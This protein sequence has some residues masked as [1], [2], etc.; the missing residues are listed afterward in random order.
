MKKYEGLNEAMVKQFAPQPGRR[1]LLPPLS[2]KAKVAIRCRMEFKEG[3]DAHIARH[4]TLRLSNGYILT[5][6]W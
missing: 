1:A 4:I 5:N 6:P 2:E 3:W